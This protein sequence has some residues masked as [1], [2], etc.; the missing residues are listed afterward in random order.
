MVMTIWLG[1]ALKGT[2]CPQFQFCGRSPQAL[3]ARD[4]RGVHLLHVAPTFHHGSRYVL[5][6][7]YF[8]FSFTFFIQLVF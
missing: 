7:F 6:F 1:E 2:F 4:G 3:L 5:D 8:I